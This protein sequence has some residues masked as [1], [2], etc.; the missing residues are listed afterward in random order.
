MSETLFQVAVTKNKK[1]KQIYETNRNTRKAPFAKA[2]FD[3]VSLEVKSQETGAK[4][5]LTMR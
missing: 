3:K 4:L 1:T 5:R 2:P